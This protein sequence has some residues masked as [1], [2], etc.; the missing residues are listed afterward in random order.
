MN[1]I[2]IN[3]IRIDALECSPVTKL[4]KP[5]IKLINP[6]KVPKSKKKYKQNLANLVSCLSSGFKLWLNLK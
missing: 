4:L 3:Q 6:P 5:E 2:N 1:N